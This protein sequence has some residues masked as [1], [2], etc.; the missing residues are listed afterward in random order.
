VGQLEAAVTT[1]FREA[2]EDYYD[3]QHVL[4]EA[5]KILALVRL[6]LILITVFRSGSILLHRPNLGL[7]KG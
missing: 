7:F 3:R 5:L 6:F 1:A 2:P 4:S